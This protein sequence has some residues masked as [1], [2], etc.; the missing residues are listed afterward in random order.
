[1][2]LDDKRPR[3]AHACEICRKRKRKC[4]G[5]RPSCSWC[6]ANSKECHYIE[7]KPRKRKWTDDYVTAL[8]QQIAL[9][10]EYATSLEGL[11]AA[12][13]RPKAIDDLFTETGIDAQPEP[14]NARH[15]PEP[16][17]FGSQL[18]PSSDPNLAN[19]DMSGSDIS[20]INDVSTMMWRMTIRD[21][22][23]TSFT[24]PSG[25][26]CFPTL[27]H[28][29]SS[30]ANSTEKPTTIQ[31]HETSRPMISQESKLYLLDVFSQSINRTHQFLDSS[32]IEL[33]KDD[34][35]PNMDLLQSAVLAAG[36]VLSDAPESQI[37]GT[38]LSSYARTI[39][40]HQCHSNPDVYTVQALGILCWR[41]LA[42]DEE[43]M[44]WMY[45]CASLKFDRRDLIKIV[46]I[47]SFVSQQCP[48]VYVFILVFMSVP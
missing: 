19:V 16:E 13:T 15:S 28:E 42:L 10:Q 17:T 31:V 46:L 18:P 22:G 21:D 43:N 33:L 7:E 27:N 8:E 14:S 41:E 1:M 6:N 23:E 25:N 48:R 30:A 29:V 9:L 24:G 40:L 35:P 36:T 5:V 26:F 44:A 34:P 4:D 11:D 20:A 47:P 45:N 39:A 12:S 38:N 2:D 37:L 32:T 3:T